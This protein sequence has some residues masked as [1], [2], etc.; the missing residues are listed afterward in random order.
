MNSVLKG[1]CEQY[2]T[3]SF[4]L[5]FLV[6]WR[7]MQMNNSL[8][9]LAQPVCEWKCAN[10]NAAN[11]IK[12]DNIR[13]TF[14]DDDKELSVYHRAI[15]ICCCCCCCHTILAIFNHWLSSL[16]TDRFFSLE[17]NALRRNWFC[18]PDEM[19]IA[20]HSRLTHSRLPICC[21]SFWNQFDVINVNC[22][23][24]WD[25][26]PLCAHK[27][28]HISNQH[29]ETKLANERLQTLFRSSHLTHFAAR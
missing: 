19:R 21:T 6:L 1:K 24:K 4:F 26:E 5:R 15:Q 8:L 12:T 20:L 25:T 2:W 14:D 16:S 27:G 10:S 29:H 28:T 13:F 7:N 11:K 18:L 17:W 23:I 3:C 22:M 9:L